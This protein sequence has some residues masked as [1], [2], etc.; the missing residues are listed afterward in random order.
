MA[1]P[2]ITGKTLDN[3]ELLA[4]C[5]RGDAGAWQQLVRKYASLVHS[6]PV[7]YGLSPAEVDDVGQDVFLALAQHLHQIEDPQSLPAWFIT[8][9][10]RLSWRALQK[11]QREQPL[12]EVDLA[13]AEDRA[14]VHRVGGGAPSISELMT[15]WQRQEVLAQGLA[16]LPER[17]RQ[18]LMLIFLDPDEPSYDDISEKLAMAKGS[19]GPTRNRCLQQFRLILEGLGFSARD[20]HS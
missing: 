16:R 9:T 3:A 20:V 4:R 18:L 7:R 12:V 2:M 1:T 14:G 6:I 8:T 5:Q 17:C 19:I 13:E 11:R 15:G 10:R